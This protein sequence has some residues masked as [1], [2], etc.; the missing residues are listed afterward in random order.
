MVICDEYKLL[1]LSKPKCF[2]TS[3]RH[4]LKP[5]GHVVWQK[6]DRLHPHMCAKEVRDFFAETGRDFDSYEKIATAREPESLLRSFFNWARCDTQN[7]YYWMKG[8]DGSCLMSFPEW[9]WNGKIYDRK[10]KS[11]TSEKPSSR[12]RTPRRSRPSIVPM[13]PILSMNPA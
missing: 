5:F 10:T 8:W 4:A 13:A 7:R 12:A 2:S 11:W 6:E 9:F 1:F 3:V